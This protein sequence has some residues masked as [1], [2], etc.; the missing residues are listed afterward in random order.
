MGHM[1]K[2]SDFGKRGRVGEL[3]GARQ[4]VLQRRYSATPSFKHGLHAQLIAKGAA[5]K[6]LRVPLIRESLGLHSLPTLAS[7][8]L[9]SSTSVLT[10]SGPVTNRIPS[11]PRL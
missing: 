9:S 2:F 5:M 1:A 4:S 7:Q 6:C 11:I 3:V 10:F 8:G